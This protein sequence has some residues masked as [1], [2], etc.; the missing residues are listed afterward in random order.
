MEITGKHSVVSRKAPDQVE[1]G[2]AAAL[3]YSLLD[4]YVDSHECAGEA[5][6]LGDIGADEE[7]GGS[8]CALDIS[9]I[10]EGVGGVM[11]LI[12]VLMTL[13][14]VLVAEEHLN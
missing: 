4:I 2:Q 7:T 5:I 13:M 1:S 11:A 10:N 12:L 8:V 9:D 3:D 6:D 14:G